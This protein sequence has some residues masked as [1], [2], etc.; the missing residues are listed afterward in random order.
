MILTNDVNCAN[1]FVSYEIKSSMK[2][3]RRFRREKYPLPLSQM[4]CQR[5]NLFEKPM[6]IMKK[7]Q[8]VILMDCLSLTMKNLYKN[9]YVF[10]FSRF[11]LIIK[12]L[13]LIGL[14]HAVMSPQ[15]TKSFITLLMKIFIWSLSFAYKTLVSLGKKV[16][17]VCLQIY[18]FD[19]RVYLQ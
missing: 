4:V 12:Y 8:G 1:R 3:W 16:K 13:I 18:F 7:K 17:C 5:E 15:P 10:L 11:L 19:P 6:K 9:L 14:Y 2:R